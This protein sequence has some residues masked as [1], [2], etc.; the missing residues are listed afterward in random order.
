MKKK[1]FILIFICLL[2]S[3]IINLNAD[4]NKNLSQDII[5]LIYDSVY[6]VVIKKPFDTPFTKEEKI[7]NNREN[8]I[9][10]D[11]LVYEEELPWDS[12]TYSEKADEYY[13]IG[14]AFA[15]SKDTFI[16]A[17]HVVGLDI[18]ILWDGLYLRDR[19]GNISEINQ[20]NENNK[21][22]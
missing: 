5:E 3:N 14:T 22:L 4:T 2:M 19:E 7:K 6:E 11:P 20:I 18:D 17:A 12:L 9:R 1:I 21:I 10:E 8:E 15:I 13:S 16:S